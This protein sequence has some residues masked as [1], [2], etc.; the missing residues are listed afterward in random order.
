[1]SRTVLGLSANWLLK[2]PTGTAELACRKSVKTYYA[3]PTARPAREKCAG[4]DHARW[5]GPTFTPDIPRPILLTFDPSPCQT[6]DGV[7][8]KRCSGTVQDCCIWSQTL[9]K[10]VTDASNDLWCNSR[11]RKKKEKYRVINCR[12][13]CWRASWFFL[14]FRVRFGM[15]RF[16]AHAVN[17]WPFSDKWF[18]ITTLVL[19]H[20]GC[21]TSD[22]S[23]RCFAGTSDVFL[24]TTVIMAECWM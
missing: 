18:E 11:T 19:S 13:V 3:G 10:A 15:V 6:S 2:S 9:V 14:M 22:V 20:S 17:A 12:R 21:C 24:D 1:M 23:I 8:L 4:I 16:M 5:H 7:G